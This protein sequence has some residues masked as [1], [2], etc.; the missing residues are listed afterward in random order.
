MKVLILLLVMLTASSAWSAPRE[1][2][3]G[4]E[5]NFIIRGGLS[6]LSVFFKTGS[7]IDNSEQDDP[8]DPDDD[9]DET[10]TP[11]YGFT[12]SV[13]RRWTQFEIVFGSDVYFGKIKDLTFV[14]ENRSIR[15]SGHFRVVNL[16]PTVKYI[17]PFVLLNKAQFYVGAGPN[18]SLQT[19]VFSDVV[20]VGGFNNNNRVSFENYGG[21]I[22]FGIE[23]ITPY[24]SSHPAYL[25]LGYSYMNSYEVSIHD[26]SKETD[27]IT[28]SE[29]SSRKF[30]GHYFI[31]RLGMTLF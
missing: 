21:N 23:E 17:T 25:E 8:A 27:V 10:K 26:A 16:G 28:L 5:N 29:K 4:M 12:T 22:Y 20:G 1:L 24:K 18:W 9:F 13:A 3:N 2:D 11:G 31:V 6:F 14:S 7:L 19:F 30:S 15:G